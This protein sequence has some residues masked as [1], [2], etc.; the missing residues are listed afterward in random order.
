MHPWHH[1]VA[2]GDSFTEGI[3][4]SVDGFAKL[5]AVDR[6]AAA[7]RQSSPDLR[8]TNLAQRGLVVSEIREQQLDT[9]LRL[10]PDLVSVVAGANDIMS[11]R[12]S[13]DRW[14]TEF[15][16]V[17]ETLTQA[18]AT[19]IAANIP[20]FPVLRTLKEPLQARVM[21]NI[22]R[23]NGVIERLAAHYQ[24]ILVDA[25]TVSQQTDREDWSEDGVHLNSRGYFK[26]AKE[27]LGILEQQTGL[28]IGGIEAD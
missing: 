18:G 8:Y 11:G 21:G 7:L 19:V 28:K 12:F 20:E 4:D 23:G 22:A 27:V 1:F 13:A 6:I 24:V 9:A 5:G 3:G 10:D 2:I 17:Y 25:W 14:E 15:Q 26:F 16:I